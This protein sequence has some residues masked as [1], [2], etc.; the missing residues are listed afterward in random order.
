MRRGKAKYLVS[1]HH[2]G[3]SLVVALDEI[4]DHVL[5]FHVGPSVW[6]EDHIPHVDGLRESVGS[7]QLCQH[8]MQKAAVVWHVVRRNLCQG[9]LHR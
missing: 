7:T 3:R 4:L 2:R 1:D 5:Q 6:W 9:D 8:V